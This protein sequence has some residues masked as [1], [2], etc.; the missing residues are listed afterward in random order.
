MSAVLALKL[1]SSTVRYCF[2]AD[3]E[4]DMLPRAL[5]FL[6][7]RGWSA[8]SGARSKRTTR[9]EPKVR[10]GRAPARGDAST[11]GRVKRRSIPPTR[12]RSWP[13]SRPIE[14]EAAEVEAALRN[15]VR[16]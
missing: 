2:E 12:R 16:V 9:C 6:A 14:R 3:A 8:S 7:K 10:A 13:S 5:E 1:N 4:P 11:V 15:L